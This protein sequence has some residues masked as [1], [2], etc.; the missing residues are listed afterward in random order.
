MRKEI[1]YSI[2]RVI[3]TVPIKGSFVAYRERVYMGGGLPKEKEGVTTANFIKC[4]QTDLPIKTPRVRI[5]DGVHGYFKLMKEQIKE[6]VRTFPYGYD[7]LFK[8]FEECT[9][10]KPFTHITE[11]G[12]EDVEL[13][14]YASDDNLYALDKIA[15]PKAI[16]FEYVTALTDNR[17]Y[18][19]E[20]MVEVLSSRPDIKFIL[21]P[22]EKVI[23]GIPYYNAEEGRDLCIEFIWYPTEETF[24]LVRDVFLSNRHSDRHQCLIETVFGIK[25]KEGR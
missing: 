22:W 4:L 15:L 13:L 24:A 19:L 2:R 21:S 10:E 16:H 17:H 5:R 7:E 3:E 11:N 8:Q 20:K 1:E 6:V 9:V 18:D 23:K 25:R 14:T 12:L